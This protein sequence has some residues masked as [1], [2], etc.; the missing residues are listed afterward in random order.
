MDLL[1]ESEARVADYLDDKLQT[2]G[3]LDSLDALLA[4]IHTQHGLLKQQV[5]G[6]PPSLA[7]RN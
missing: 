1:D 6:S 7:L 2:L 4:N 3:D 5:R